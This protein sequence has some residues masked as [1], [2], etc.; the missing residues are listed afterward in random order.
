MSDPREIIRTFIEQGDHTGWFDALYTAADGNPDRVPWAGLAPNPNLVP[1]LTNNRALCDSLGRRAL[2]VGCGLGDDAEELASRDFDVTAFDISE[3]AIAWCKKRWPNTNVRY[4]TANLFDLRPGFEFDFVFE[5]YTI[6]ALPLDVRTRA[7]NALAGTVA[8]GGHLLYVGRGRE[9]GSDVQGP[10]WAVSHE[11]L[12]LLVDRGL[13]EV[14]FEDYTDMQDHRFPE[15]LRRFR[16]LYRR[17][18]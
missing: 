10:P 15:G 8:P 11:E 2:V 17:A 12:N 18:D 3:A 7:L 5:A 16:A 4:I 14:T 13:D 6:Q 1:W 9:G